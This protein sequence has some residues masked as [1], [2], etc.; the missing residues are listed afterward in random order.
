MNTLI[1][2]AV[3]ILATWVM[4]SLVPLWLVLLLLYAVQDIGGHG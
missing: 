4:P 1:A 2:C 3:A